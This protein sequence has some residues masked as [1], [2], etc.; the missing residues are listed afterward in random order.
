M[1]QP[2]LVRLQVPPAERVEATGEGAPIRQISI[3]PVCAHV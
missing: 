1:S 3:V 2:A